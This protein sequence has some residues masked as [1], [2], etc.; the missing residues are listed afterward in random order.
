MNN[1]YSVFDIIITYFCI[2]SSLQDIS[3]LYFILYYSFMGFYKEF[4]TLN[5]IYVAIFYGYAHPYR[6]NE[7]NVT[8][9]DYVGG[10]VGGREHQTV[11]QLF[12][13]QLLTGF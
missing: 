1:I 7:A 5:E 10:I 6:D 3:V 11:Q 2:F 12:H 13:G 8:G 4:Y 9:A